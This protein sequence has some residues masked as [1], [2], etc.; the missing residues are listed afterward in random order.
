MIKINKRPV[1][2]GLLVFGLLIFVG[3]TASSLNL[4]ATSWNLSE[5]RN[6]AGDLVDPI[7]DSTVTADFQAEKVSGLAGCNN[8]S[9]S[10]QIERKNLTFSPPLS[11]RKLC[12]TPVGI[13]SQENDFLTN[14]TSVSEYQIK[15][16]QLIF[17]DSTGKIVLT[18][19]QK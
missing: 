2:L 9:A 14:L 19:S 7:M 18:F 13:M 6:A 10:Y 1:V 17:S 4:D 5:Y 11:T 3:C 15:G 12:S 16:D 8:Y